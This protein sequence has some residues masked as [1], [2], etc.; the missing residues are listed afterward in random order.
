MSQGHD[1]CDTVPV[2]RSA[3]VPFAGRACTRTWVRPRG[4]VA[5]T[6]TVVPPSRFVPSAGL[7]ML[8]VAGLLSTVRVTVVEIAVLPAM[9]VAT[10]RKS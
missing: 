1:S 9:S 2:Q 8:T 5:D 7:V 3:K 10:A 4:A 6:A